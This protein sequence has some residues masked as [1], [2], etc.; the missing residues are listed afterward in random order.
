MK[1]EIHSISPEVYY[2]VD[3]YSWPG[4]FWE[5]RSAMEYAVNMMKL[6]G[7]ITMEE[8]PERIRFEAEEKEEESLNLEVM[9]KRM[10]EK[11]IA[12]YGSGT[13]NKKKV[14][15]VLGIGVATLYR[16]IKKYGLERV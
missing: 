12:R 4:N 14:A 2:C 1:K 5:V 6:D 7:K 9:E 15:K 8:L 13:E 3:A 16:K 10:I 11:A